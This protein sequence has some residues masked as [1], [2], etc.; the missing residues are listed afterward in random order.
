MGKDR[1]TCE[2][3]QPEYVKRHLA[4]DSSVVFIRCEGPGRLYA[5]LV[6]KRSLVPDFYKMIEGIKDAS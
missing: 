1:L 4:Y 3:Y 6:G 2:E 5:T